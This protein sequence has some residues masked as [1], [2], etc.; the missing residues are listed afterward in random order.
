MVWILSCQ[1]ATQYSRCL[2]HGPG[3]S[4]DLMLY[5]LPGLRSVA[6]PG[7]GYGIG[8]TW[9]DCSIPVILVWRSIHLWMGTVSLMQFSR[10][11]G[12]CFAHE[13]LLTR[14]LNHSSLK[15]PS[16]LV[17]ARSVC[18]RRSLSCR[19]FSESL[20]SC[21]LKSSFWSSWKCPCFLSS[22]QWTKCSMVDCKFCIT[23]A[24]ILKWSHLLFVIHFG[25][26]RSESSDWVVQRGT[27]DSCSLHF[28]LYRFCVCLPPEEI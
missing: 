4:V 24:A 14:C 16:L 9:I 21:L 28:I 15:M 19:I 20:F 17:N 5:K 7:A 11:E 12:E 23:R 25:S 18:I 22:S 13:Y 2:C 26:C 10:E 8:Y 1:T 3:Y 27:S 6:A